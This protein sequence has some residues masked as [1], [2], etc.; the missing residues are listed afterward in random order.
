MV[1]KV[2]QR[3]RQLNKKMKKYELKRER[4]M[5]DCTQNQRKK[6]ST[7]D[8]VLVMLGVGGAWP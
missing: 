4:A 6:T 8:K 3:N 7:Q 5:R 1:F 2:K